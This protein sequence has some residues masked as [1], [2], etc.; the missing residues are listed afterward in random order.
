M[1]DL[2]NW[3]QY[4]VDID[5]QLLSLPFNEKNMEVDV[6]MQHSINGNIMI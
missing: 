5:M 2:G 1:L 3:F 6:N 4:Q